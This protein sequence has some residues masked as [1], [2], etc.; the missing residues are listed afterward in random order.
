MTER[1]LRDRYARFCELLTL[2]EEYF[3]ARDF[4]AA[5]GLAQ[6]AVCC[7]FPDHS[8]LFASP[9]L[10]RLLLELGKQIPAAAAGRARQR[11]ETSLN[12]LHVLTY[13]RPLGGDTRFA[14][15][16]IQE[17]RSNRHSVAIT[18]QAHMK[19]VYTV[20][21]VL[22]QAAEDSGGFLRALRASASRPLEQARE[23]RALCQEMDIV[24]LH[25]W[26]YDIVPIL[27]LAAGCESVKTLFVNLSDHT[28]W[29]GASVAH[30]VVHLRRQSPHFLS[31]RRRLDPDRSVILPIPLADAPSSI[32]SKAEKLQAKRM[33]GYAPDVTLLLTIATPFKYSAPGQIGLLDLV[34]PVLVQ[35]PQAVFMAVGPQ[36]DNAWHAASTQTHGRI[37]PLGT[38][39]DNDL[40]RT[41]ADV[42][43][44]SVPFSSITSLLESGIRGLPVLAY[45][46]PNPE[47]ALLGP[48]APGLEN[49]MHLGSDPESYRKLLGSLIGDERLRRESGLRLR[50]H[51]LSLHSGP[52]WVNALHSLYARVQQANGRGCFLAASD[53]FEGGPLDLALAQLYAHAHEPKH[54]YRLIRNYVGA[55]PYRSRLSLTRRLHLKGFEVSFLSLLPPPANAIVRGIG[56]PAKRMIWRLRQLR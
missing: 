4:Q 50:E 52:N 41:A 13:A 15:R 54:V 40:L 35:F 8:G 45:N 2:A 39:Q 19:G 49:A 55:M 21:E 16:W 34:T 5:A 12:I 29:A 56:R 6:I 51:I 36:R 17:D 33:L 53:A 32:P 23:L 24:V 47:M 28:F 43:L 30:S 25:L 3:A 22:R 38:R 31:N 1:L 37:V 11:D 44:D 42:C 18:T 14:W 46:P 7:A 10:E 27:A 26:P 20:P 9:R 48:G